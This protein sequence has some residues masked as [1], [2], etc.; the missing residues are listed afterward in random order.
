M[1]AGREKSNKKSIFGSFFTNWFSVSIGVTVGHV[2]CGDSAIFYS[3]DS[4]V[5]FGVFDGV[6]GEPGADR[7]SE[8]AACAMLS[9]LKPLLVCDANQMKNALAEASRNI[10]EGYTTATVAFIRKDGTFTIGSIGDSPVYGHS[11]GDEFFRPLLPVARMVGDNDSILKFLYYRNIVTH[12][13]GIEPVTNKEMQIAILTGKLN[14]ADKIILA[15]DGLSDNLFFG[16]NEGYVTDS[17][18][19][20]DLTNIIGQEMSGSKI[21]SKIKF[22]LHSNFPPSAI[23][24]EKIAVLPRIKT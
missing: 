13:L 16:V 23:S 12:V 17:F 8:S 3:D 22:F 11:D 10:K 6:S 7:A 21:L 5:V 15:T 4:K 19:C 1:F 24:L 14:P 2:I 20:E 18:G 9:I